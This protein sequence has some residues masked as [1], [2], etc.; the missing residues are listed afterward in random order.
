MIIRVPAPAL[1]RL[2]PA[3]RLADSARPIIGLQGRRAARAAARGRR[4]AP[5]QFPAPA[6]LGRPGGPRRADP[7]PARTAAD[8][9]A[10]HPVTVLRWHRR[11]VTGKWTC[12]NRTGRPPVGAE[13]AALIER[14]A[15][16]NNGWGVPADPRRAAETR[17]PG[18]R[19][20]HP[21]GAQSPEDPPGAEAAHRP[22]WPASSCIPGGVSELGHW[23]W[24]GFRRGSLVFVEEAAEGGPTQDSLLE[25]NC[26]R[27]VRPGR[28]ELAAAM[29]ASSIVVSLILGQDRSSA[30]HLWIIE[31]GLPPGKFTPPL[32]I[33][34]SASPPATARASGAHLAPQRP[35]SVQRGHPAQPS[36]DGGPYSREAA[37][38]QAKVDE[39]AEASPPSSRPTLPGT[40]TVSSRARAPVP[41]HCHLTLAVSSKG[42]PG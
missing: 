1:S 10:G 42:Q 15:T 41:D 34:A 8:A 18:R 25:K 17:P 11:L 37:E 26:D 5:R 39:L 3:L 21:T 23:C 30:S 40:A 16:E 29:G 22:T 6:R 27:V 31:T 9:P 24:P 4:A 20:H 32:I 33:A 35:R 2:R 19:V 12:P 38:H 36:S 7:A 14:L 28:A 13:I